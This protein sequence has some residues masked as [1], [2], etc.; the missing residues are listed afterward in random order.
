MVYKP[1]FCFGKNTVHI[2]RHFKKIFDQTLGYVLLIINTLE[3]QENKRLLP[4]ILGKDK[5][6][7]EK[8]NFRYALKKV[9]GFR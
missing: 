8:L 2:F 3:F 5:G 9:E 6:F 1:H 4:E 7:M